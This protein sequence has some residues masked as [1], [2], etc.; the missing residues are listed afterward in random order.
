MAQIIMDNFSKVFLKP[1]CMIIFLSLGWVHR[2][3]GM[4]GM[5]NSLFD[6]D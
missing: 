6:D 2:N 1:T 4:V 5:K 3:V